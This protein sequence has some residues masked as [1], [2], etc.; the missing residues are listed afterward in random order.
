MERISKENFANLLN[1]LYDIFNPEHKSYVSGLVERNIDVPM[2]SVDMILFKYNQEHLDF[3]DPEMNNP[4]YHMNLVSQ[5]A[6]GNRPLQELDISKR[7]AEI[8]AQK[9]AA[10]QQA[11]QKEL[12]R[13]KQLQDQLSSQAAGIEKKTQEEINTIKKEMEKALQE[14]H[15]IRDE[16]KK[17]P[18]DDGVDYQLRINYTQEE[19]QLP[20]A[21]KLAGLGIGA[22]IIAKTTQGRPI[23]LVVKD[24]SYDD[25]SHPEGRTVIDIILDKG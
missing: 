22:R 4:T 15:T 3:Y 1:D 16:A 10:T 8:Q 24:I 6:K 21:K 19:I 14:I 12:D 25:F 13:Q 2:D 18:E 11:Q 20:N 23:G 7:R 17:N 9:D 5:Y